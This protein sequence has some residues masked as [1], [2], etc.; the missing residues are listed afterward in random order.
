MLTVICEKDGSSSRFDVLRTIAQGVIEDAGL[1]GFPDYPGA[2][3]RRL[4]GFGGFVHSR[5]L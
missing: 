5:F 3:Q 2:P 4:G 1:I